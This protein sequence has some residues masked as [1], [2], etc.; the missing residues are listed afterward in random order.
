MTP[1]DASVSEGKQTGA[2]APAAQANGDGASTQATTQPS[3][4]VEASIAELQRD[5]AKYQKDI[6]SL[7]SARDKDNAESE[8]R[9]KEQRDRYEKQLTALMDDD[10]RAEYETSTREARLQELQEKAL[11]AQTALERQ[12]ASNN[13]FATFTERGVPADV[14]L[15]AY[16]EGP[17]AM[18]G[19]AWEWLFDKANSTPAQQTSSSNTQDS[20]DE[21][22]PAP[23]V[24]TTTTGTPYSGPS[25]KE[26]VEEHG[27]EDNVYT[28]VE[29]GILPADAIPEYREAKAK[30]Q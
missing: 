30:S 15:K 5:I 21:A 1:K 28:L 24:V 9:I 26:L 11:N 13:V 8:R 14:L 6:N 29:N 25:W 4:D 3:K 16:A 18:A 17:E 27:S 2:A 23:K 12:Q 19:L 10:A 7:K 20:E 22:T